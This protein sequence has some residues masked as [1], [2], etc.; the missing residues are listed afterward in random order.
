VRG[1]VP[2]ALRSAE[3]SLE[4][5]DAL[6]FSMARP[7][8]RLALAQVLRVAGRPAEAAAHLREAEHLANEM[9]SPFVLHAVFLVQAEFALAD[10]AETAAVDLLRHALSLAEARGF[11][12]VFWLRPETMGRL[13][14][15]ALRKRIHVG[16][17]EELVRRRGLLPDG[18][19]QAWPWRLKI[20]ALGGFVASLDGGKPAKVKG[21][22]L[23]MLQA[24]VA[25]GPNAVAQERLSDALWPDSDGDAARR[26]FDVTLH[27]LRKLL[28]DEELVRLE[29]GH[30]ALD[31]RRAWVDANAFEATAEV[32]VR[33]LRK[34][35]DDE[36]RRAAERRND[37]LFSLYRG[38]LLGAGHHTFSDARRERLRNLFVSCVERLGD[39]AERAQS[40]EEAV[41]LYERGLAADPLA[42]SL[43]R[44]RIAALL[45]M[46]RG[47]EARRAFEQCRAA[48]RQG[49]G[50]EP[51]VA[52]RALV[53]H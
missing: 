24:I 31:R 28:G 49:L 21:M 39:G 27:R 8:M 44:R 25:L 20:N 14:T 41:L 46:D 6:G 40:L 15:L 35:Q 29:D 22:P 45:R 43:H 52:T 26:V 2:R 30:V 48:L 17:V 1:E 7:G 12:N 34:P 36:D 10:G 4:M 51:S 53:V 18:S 37:E 11:F 33:S 19:V 9:R 32:L 38:P 50:V 3:L 23:R 47:A 16:Y 42:E 5:A 13:A